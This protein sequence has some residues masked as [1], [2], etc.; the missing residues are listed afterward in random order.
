MSNG[1]T[2]IPTE[3]YLKLNKKFHKYSTLSVVMCNECGALVP[4]DQIAKHL[5]ISHQLDA[6]IKTQGEAIKEAEAREHI[7]KIR[8]SQWRIGVSSLS[9]ETCIY[10][11]WGV[12]PHFFDTYVCTVKSREVAQDIIKEHNQSRMTRR[13]KC[14]T[15]TSEHG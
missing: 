10:A 14:L 15:I 12:K 3:W 13:E 9:G 8:C 11:M 4:E 6:S 2:P 1:T 5:R 7:L